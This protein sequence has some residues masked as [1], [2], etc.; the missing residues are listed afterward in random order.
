MP[1]SEV[2]ASNVEESLFRRIIESAPNAIVVVERS[3]RIVLV[4]TQT[5]ILFGYTRA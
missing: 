5:E 4:N 2:S 1:D 3:G